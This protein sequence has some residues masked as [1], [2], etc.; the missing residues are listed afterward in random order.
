MELVCW[1]CRNGRHGDC[2]GEVPVGD[3]SEGPHDCSFDNRMVKCAC[4][5][6]DCGTI[7]QA[8]GQRF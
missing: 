8:P 6:R 1:F 5:H 4:G 2:M 3:D 7:P